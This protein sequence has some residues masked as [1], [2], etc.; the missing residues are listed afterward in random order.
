MPS[1][2][3]LCKVH[4]DASHGS[5]AGN[6]HELKVVQASRCLSTGAVEH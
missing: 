2:Q 1:A 4:F 3:W 5:H 6:G